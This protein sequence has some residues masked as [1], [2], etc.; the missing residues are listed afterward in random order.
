MYFSEPDV[1]KTS[2]R[3]DYIIFPNRVVSFECLPGCGYCCSFKVPVL[4]KDLHRLASETGARGIESEE[5]S[6]LHLKRENGFCTFLDDNSRCSVYEVRPSFCRMYPFI[7]ETL[8]NIE[9][10]VDLSCPGIGFG[11]EFSN[12]E[13]KTKLEIEASMHEQVAHLTEMR[14][15]VR[16]I[17]EFLRK[18]GNFTTPYY[19]SLISGKILEDTFT[20]RTA[21]EG[22]RLFQIRSEAANESAVDFGNIESRYQAENFTDRVMEKITIDKDAPELSPD[23]LTDSFTDKKLTTKLTTNGEVTLYSYHYNYSDNLFILQLYEDQDSRV[24]I[25]LDDARVNKFTEKAKTC[26]C[27][28]IRIWLSRQI[29]LRY[30]FAGAFGAL[31]GKNCIALYIGFFRRVLE[32]LFVLSNIISLREDK[33]NILESHVMEAVRGTDN[34]MRNLCRIELL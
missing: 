10:D 20:G 34:Y 6:D 28:Y 33:D 31:H 17:E 14:K 19:L 1:L 13:L 24:E 2:L 21:G 23:M 30:C 3:K 12:Q 27:N 7:R 32:R 26:L 8:Y 15:K 22:I 4:D 5:Q 25:S 18:R 16:P 9:I 29:P 11:K